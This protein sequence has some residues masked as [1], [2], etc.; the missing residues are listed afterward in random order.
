MMLFENAILD[1][2]PQQNKQLIS[3]LQ[4]ANAYEKICYATTIC[5]ADSYHTR[6]LQIQFWKAYKQ[7]YV[8]LFQKRVS[9]GSLSK[10]DYIAYRT[11]KQY[12]NVA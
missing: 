7:G 2:S 4:N 5:L 3:W 6:M 11:T 12:V 1:P 10:Y 8:W 9:K